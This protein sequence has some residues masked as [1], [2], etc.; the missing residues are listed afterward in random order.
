MILE[1]PAP[2][3]AAEAV[4]KDLS[5]AASVAAHAIRRGAAVELVTGDGVL[6]FDT[7]EAHLDR[8]LEWLAVYVPPAAPRVVRSPGNAARE[9]RMRLGAGRE[10]EGGT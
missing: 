2:E 8:V 9:V 1:D 6:P 3:A 5:Y 4:E 10:A 7:G